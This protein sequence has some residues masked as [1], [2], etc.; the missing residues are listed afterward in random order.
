MR[1]YDYDPS[2]EIDQSKIEIY[3]SIDQGFFGSVYLVKYN[4]QFAALKC[5][6]G[7]YTY[8][9]QFLSKDG[10]LFAGPSTFLTFDRP[11]SPRLNPY[12]RFLGPSPS[13]IS[14][15]KIQNHHWRR[16]S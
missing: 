3:Y 5:S 4:N 11:L 2:I 9:V 13:V 15:K 6:K 14:G 16:H 1:E 12:P 10:T 7:E 8:T